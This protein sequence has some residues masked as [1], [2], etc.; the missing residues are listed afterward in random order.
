MD[1]GN[2][3]NFS[4]NDDSN[5]NYGQQSTSENQQYINPN[6][7]QNSGYNIQQN[8][9]GQQNSGYVQ[10]NNMYNQQPQQQMYGQPQQQ[11]PYGQPQQQ[12]YGQ[13]PYGVP[14]Q[15]PFHSGVTDVME[16]NKK[17]AKK[18]KKKKKHK[19]LRFLL[20]CLMIWAAVTGCN[21]LAEKDL[22]L[23]TKQY[24]FEFTT[25]VQSEAYVTENFNVRTV[26]ET[27]KGNYN[28]EW[29]ENSK[30]L[31]I[32]EDG[33]VTIT[34]PESQMETVKI[35]LVYKKFFI[36]KA[37]K[38]YYITL[39][40]SG[41]SA[42]NTDELNVSET[43]NDKD[44]EFEKSDDGKI[45]YL[46]GGLDDIK[47]N[48]AE[49]AVALIKAYAPE[50]GYDLTN[51]ELSVNKID[52]SINML[53]YKFNIVYSGVVLNDESAVVVVDKETN[54][55][56]KVSIDFDT[57][58]SSIKVSEQ[59][60]S[61][62]EVITLVKNYCKENYKDI[63]VM[64][65][66]MEDTIINGEQCK[67]FT[68]LFADGAPYVLVYN[69]IS[70]EVVSFECVVDTFDLNPN[71][72]ITIKG[73]N[74]WGETVRVDG[75][76]EK[77]ILGQNKYVLYD[78]GRGIHVYDNLN[79]WNSINTF[80]DPDTP[81]WLQVVA[82]PGALIELLV[83]K[84]MN[85]EISHTSNDFDDKYPI[86][87][88]V[89]ENIQD[90]YDWYYDNL[91]LTSYDNKGAE[92][93]ILDDCDFGVDNAAWSGPMG[94][95]MINPVEQFKYSLG[96]YV[97]CLGHEY[98]HAVFGDKLSGSNNEVAGLNEAY[99]D[100][101]GYLI[102]GDTQWILINGNYVNGDKVYLRTAMD[103]TQTSTYGGASYC[104]D[105]SAVPQ[106]YH[107]DAWYACGEEEHLISKMI[108]HV[109][110]LMY[111]SGLFTE[112]ELAEIWFNSLDYGYD[113]DS[114]YLTCRKYVIK[115]AD[116]YNCSDEQ[117]DF[118][119][120]A[121]DKIGVYDETYEKRVIDTTGM[122]EEEIKQLELDELWDEERKFAL[123]M[124][125]IGSFVGTTKIYIW[126]CGDD[127][128]DEELLFIQNRIDSFIESELQLEFDAETEEL[129]DSMGI[130]P[131]IEVEYKQLNPITFSIIEKFINNSNAQ[132]K[133]ML[134]QS[135][136]QSVGVDTSTDE[137]ASNFIENLM[138]LVFI[139]GV[140]ED[141]RAEFLGVDILAQ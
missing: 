77:N 99:A 46:L 17:K 85:I 108:S 94:V 112:Q 80:I 41:E 87:I 74:E 113:S 29:K 133:D 70:N 45:K 124:S 52:N 9:Y 139:A 119:A 138:S 15:E 118:I 14:Q 40:P 129:M 110:C 81:E 60:L 2:G 140:R 6:I 96:S 11:N 98:T 79:F 58:V 128:S 8:E 49:D 31:D 107:D 23:F 28:V 57:D 83:A 105:A 93:I 4:G 59:T 1:I 136:E 103:L 13:P 97:E 101:F 100:I 68:L 24:P 50:M 55:V 47:V 21:K 61:N 117:V 19:F 3:N 25:S 132:V 95:F 115:S 16:Q 82:T 7:S 76:Y 38:D 67:K 63:D 18:R 90:S 125:P 75:S 37:T 53:T 131:T 44:V 48:S 20:F 134:T 35:T 102:K 66:G 69:I 27:S 36:G 72:A 91:G 34:K 26:F 122:T 141:T 109:G 30:L 86:S 126:E 120:E 88:Q 123:F 121:F 106:K 137:E 56:Q 10:Q 39:V 65:Y 135:F 51:V 116:Y 104:G 62:E 73:E 12:M 127:L 54:E 114:T 22:R 84:N 42:L 92:I 71:T 43:L 5:I 130:N 78:I 33:S 89:M 64:I 111:S 32:A